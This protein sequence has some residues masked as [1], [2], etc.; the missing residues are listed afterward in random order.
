MKDF[1][2]D[3]H[4]MPSWYIKD[5]WK[6]SCDLLALEGSPYTCGRQ[7][8]FQRYN[9]SI[10]CPQDMRGS[11]CLVARG[12]EWQNR[13][14]WKKLVAHS[15]LYGRRPQARLIPSRVETC[16]VLVAVASRMASCASVSALCHTVIQVPSPAD[17]ATWFS[18]IAQVSTHT[19]S[20]YCSKRTNTNQMCL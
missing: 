15:T 12:Y 17:R 2:F 18:I 16:T 6:V 13:K 10:I 14:C 11:V 5:C 4:W 19:A 9:I 7:T 1:P 20:H 8:I 3:R